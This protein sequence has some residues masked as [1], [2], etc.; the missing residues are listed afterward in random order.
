MNSRLFNTFTVLIPTYER[1]E[2]V[3]RNLRYMEQAFPMSEMRIFVL[4]GSVD[5]AKTT[6]EICARYPSVCYLHYDGLSLAD[7]LLEGLLKVKTP[8]VSILADD[9]LLIPEGLFETLSFLMANPDYSVAS[10]RYMGYRLEKSGDITFKPIFRNIRSIDN[11]SPY[12][13]YYELLADY[14]PIYYSIHKT[15]VLLKAYQANHELTQYVDSGHYTFQELLLALTEVFHGKFK[16]LDSYYY[17]RELDQ[18]VPYIHN[19]M[20]P[21]SV[22]LK[23]YT[24]EEYGHFKREMGKLLRSAA[25][26]EMSDQELDE[27]M[28][29]CLAFYIG[30]NFTSKRRFK[31]YRH[32]LAKGPFALNFDKPTKDFKYYI[33]K[34]TGRIRERISYHQLQREMTYLRQLPVSKF[35]LTYNPQE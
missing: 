2:Y 31:D 28:D 5:K 6:E 4:D 1:P 27:Y 10:G 26:N 29:L 16:K 34:H 7:R 21:I 33:T 18:S 19:F 14:F 11:P 20:P 12:Y 17:A 23:Q 9:D 24:I 30:G 35:L 8:L 13:R 25:P 22:L 3:L 15:D 32:Q